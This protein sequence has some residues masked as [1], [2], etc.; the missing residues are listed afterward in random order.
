MNRGRPE[1]QQQNRP[2]YAITTQAGGTDLASNYASALALTALALGDTDPTYSAQLIAE[3]RK[4]YTFANNY[5][6]IYSVSVPE[7]A[8]FY[9]SYEYHDELTFAASVLALVTGEQQYKTDA[10]NLYDQNGYGT[11]NQDMFDWD[12]KVKLLIITAN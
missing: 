2:C 1:Q 7:A 9:S 3:A 8:D 6:A 10:A 5:R 4:L 11:Y 12:N